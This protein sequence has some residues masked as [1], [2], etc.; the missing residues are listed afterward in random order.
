[1]YNPKYY[2]KAKRILEQRR[3]RANA[4]NEAAAEILERSSDYAVLDSKRKVLFQNL[5]ESNKKNLPVDDIAAQIEY[6]NAEIA[7]LSASLGLKIN[8][9]EC[10]ICEDTGEIN[11][12]YCTCLKKLIEEIKREETGLTQLPAFTFADHISGLN[13]ILDKI[14]PKLVEYCSTFPANTVR[15]IIFNGGVGVGKSCLAAAIANAVS[16]KGFTVQYIKSNAMNDLFLKY[17]TSPY[18]ERGGIL[19]PLMNADLLIIDDLG[20]EPLLNNVT[21]PYLYILLESR[22]KRHTIITTNLDKNEI[23]SKYKERIFSRLF[24]IDKSL[25]L[26]LSGNDLRLI[27]K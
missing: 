18:S 9:Y 12:V 24:D 10:N 19:S 2:D 16:N 26:S 5:F 1:M 25:I 14:Y 4:L 22:D 27:K 11:G 3:S 13:P 6:I 17:H 21:L 23:E 7:N 20:I 15:Q 8:N